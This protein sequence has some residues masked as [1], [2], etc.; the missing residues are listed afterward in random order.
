MTGKHRFILVSC[1]IATGLLTSAFG[2][3]SPSLGDLARQ[4]REQQAADAKD[5]KTPKVITNEEIP[6]R[7][8]KHA[9]RPTGEKDVSEREISSADNK[10]QADYWKTQIQRQK[11]QVASLKG[12]IDDLNDSIRAA[13]ANCVAR[14]VEWN[15]RQ[16]EKQHRIERL[17]MQLEDQNQRLAD[18]QES[19][20]KQGF[21]S[22]VY[23]P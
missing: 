12:E 7:A 23:D 14:C 8:M 1:A 3:D 22:S 16:K 21:G 13:P 2:Q 20:R 6:E 11:Q 10:A 5:G 18:M 15:E 19:A 4:Q 17:Q 9:S